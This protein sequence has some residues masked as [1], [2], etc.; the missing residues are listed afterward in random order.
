MHL[1]EYSLV[2]DGL[3]REMEEIGVK[4]SYALAEK[5]AAIVQEAQPLIS[6]VRNFVNFVLIY[7]FQCI[8]LPLTSLHYI[9]LDLLTTWSFKWHME[10]RRI[11]LDMDSKVKDN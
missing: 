2:L 3:G 4:R 9:C 11:N 10:L 7:C 1:L 5:T 6:K 8:T